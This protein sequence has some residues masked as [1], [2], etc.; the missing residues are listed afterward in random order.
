MP[1]IRLLRDLA[2][3]IQDKLGVTVHIET[4]ST[5]EDLFKEWDEEMPS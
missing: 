4:Q 3:K 2:K 1:T 5:L